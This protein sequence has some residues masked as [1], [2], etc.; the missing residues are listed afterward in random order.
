MRGDVVATGQWPLQ[1]IPIGKNF[2]LGNVAFKLAELPAPQEYKLVASIKPSSGE[3]IE[4]DWNFWVYPPPTSPAPSND[5]LVTRSWDVAETN[6]ASGGK[7]LYLP[8]NADL[9][10]TC[11]P[12]AT[13]PVFWNRLMNPA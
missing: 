11:P 13:T 4:N 3:P 10:W 7:V 5:V 12:L 8:R 2:P 1:T 6:L 9:D